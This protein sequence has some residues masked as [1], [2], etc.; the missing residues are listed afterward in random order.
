MAWSAGDLRLK[1]VEGAEAGE[2]LRLESPVIKIGRASDEVEKMPGWIFLKD[3]TVSRL[4]AELSWRYEIHGFSLVHHSQKN[5]TLVN[6][7]SVQTEDL[8]IGDRIQIGAVVL[9]LIRCQPTWLKET[10]PAQAVRRPAPEE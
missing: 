8:R 7:R 6:G 3:P 5:P 9:E 10:D 4:H 1:I 2:L